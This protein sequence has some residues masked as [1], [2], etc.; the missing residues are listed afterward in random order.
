MLGAMEWRFP[1]L[2]LAKGFSTTPLFFR[3]LKG[4]FFFDAGTAYDGELVD[5]AP[6]YGTGAELV[7]TAIFGYYAGGAFK[8]GIAR[9]LT[10]EEDAITDIYLLFGGGY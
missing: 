1:I 5:A 10:Q 9:G 2:D 7:L 3:R 4:R 6:L 8:L